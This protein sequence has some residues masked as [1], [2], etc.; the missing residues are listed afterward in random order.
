MISNFAFNFNE[1][2]G[3]KQGMGEVNK[4]SISSRLRIYPFS[5]VSHHECYYDVIIINQKNHT[6]GHYMRKRIYCQIGKQELKIMNLVRL[7]QKGLF[8]FF[9]YY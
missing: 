8:F 1:L 2:F 6:W 9:Q 7:I 5:P 3:L 4:I